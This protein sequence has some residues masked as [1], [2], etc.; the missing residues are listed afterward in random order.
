MIQK[1]TLLIGGRWIRPNGTNKSAIVDSYTEEQFAEVSLGDS[2]DVDAAVRAAR[3]ASLR[4]SMTHP[5]ERA[6]YLRRIRE[7]L[8]K[9]ADELAITITR[10]V[11]MPIKMSRRM[12]VDA[13]LAILEMYARHAINFVYEEQIGN[14]RIVREPVGVVG[15][16]TAWNYPLYLLVCKVAPALAAGCTVVLKPSEIAP[17]SAYAFAEAVRE[18]ELP[19]GVFNLVVGDGPIVGEALVR[20]PDVDAVTFTGSTRAGRRVAEVASG[21]AKRVALELGG[22]SASLVLDD[23][24]LPSAVKATVNMCFLNSGQTCAALTR[25][26]VSTKQHEEAVGL[27]VEIA[28]GFVP[29]DPR[30]E[31]TK[32]GPL[33]S[34]AQRDRVAKYIA[35]GISD[36]ADLLCGGPGMPTGVAK[37]YFVRPT[38][39]GRVTP[40]SVIAQEEIFG[41]VLCIIPYTDEDE[42]VAIAND[43]IYG[44]AGAV[45]SADE[46]RAESVARKLRTGQVDINGGTFNLEAPFGGYRQSGIGR[47]MGRF[48]MEEFLQYK[49]LQFRNKK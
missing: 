7:A 1:D 30:S 22:K 19:A 13:P 41:P 18:A 32:L 21:T 24:D 38:I 49:A 48:G 42:A 10:E 25:L 8:A 31:G 20:H 40:T 5:S 36:G 9:R 33:V 47:E 14:S 4:W 26:L 39:F 15:A 3:L 6:T 35:R 11:G 17:L 27:A 28:K 12:Q 16:I 37:G 2:Q 34:A 45:W 44:L 29:G 43:S 23:G 46:S